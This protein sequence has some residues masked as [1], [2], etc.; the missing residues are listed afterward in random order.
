MFSTL[1]SSELKAVDTLALEQKDYNYDT[2]TE[3]SDISRYTDSFNDNGSIGTTDDQKYRYNSNAEAH[4][5][6]IT[7]ITETYDP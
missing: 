1:E 4:D 2:D 5:E 6:G 7:G 3:M